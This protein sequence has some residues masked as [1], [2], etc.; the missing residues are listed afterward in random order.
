M[1]VRDFIKQLSVPVIEREISANNVIIGQKSL[2]SKLQEFKNVQIFAD[3]LK[4]Y[5]DSFWNEN[6]ITYLKDQGLMLSFVSKAGMLDKQIEGMN[7][8]YDSKEFKDLIA[9]EFM[10]VESYTRR[11]NE[12]EQILKEANVEL[13]KSLDA[14]KN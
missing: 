14:L 7:I 6:V 5:L 1:L 2:V 3:Q 4:F 10:H 11:I 8:L 12:L 13:E 9:M